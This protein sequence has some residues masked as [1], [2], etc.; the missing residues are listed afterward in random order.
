MR[1]I[2]SCTFRSSVTLIPAPPVILSIGSTALD[3]GTAYL[4]S[5]CAVSCRLS[6]AGRMSC[7]A[8]TSV[9][10]MRSRHPIGLLQRQRELL[11]LVDHLLQQRGGVAHAS[12]DALVAVL[13][14]RA[15]AV[16]EVADRLMREV[17]LRLGHHSTSQVIFSK[18]IS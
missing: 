8:C 3:P 5:A 2:S 7:I 10:A 14:H 15:D 13:L 6:R 16:A 12:C 9:L 11:V 18:S 1:R 4:D 17:E